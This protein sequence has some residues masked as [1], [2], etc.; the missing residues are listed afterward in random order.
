M[1][2]ENR[3]KTTRISITGKGAQCY[4]MQLGQWLETRWERP[5]GHIK[6]GLVHCCARVM[7]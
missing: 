2:G 4:W 7:L 5:Q 6:E 3:G 1:D